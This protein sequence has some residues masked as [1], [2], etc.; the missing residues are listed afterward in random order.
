[1]GKRKNLKGI[2]WAILSS[3]NSRNNDVDG[4]WGLGKLYLHANA[5]LTNTVII[6]LLNRQIKPATSKFQ[7]LIHQYQTMLARQLRHHHLSMEQVS[8]AIIT[9]QFNQPYQPKYH[10]S[11]QSLGNPYL[12]RCE[13]VS[14]KKKVHA[15]I[16]GGLCYPHDPIKDRRS[17][18]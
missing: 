16:Q 10:A 17:A 9:I 6:D 4:Y 7:P 14:D 8:T 18:R 3:F 1:M 11:A 15:S 13:I 12:C 5:H 2:S